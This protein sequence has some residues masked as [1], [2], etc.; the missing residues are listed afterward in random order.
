MSKN[1]SR[2]IIISYPDQMPLS[3]S[4]D[5]RDKNEN[6]HI[7]FLSTKPTVYKSYQSA[8]NMVRRQYRR[9]EI[10][11]THKEMGKYWIKLCR[12]RQLGTKIIRVD[13]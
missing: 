11:K 1:K 10:M 5:P 2:W 7:L 4:N 13:F 12:A 3:E 9:N 6:S 8:K